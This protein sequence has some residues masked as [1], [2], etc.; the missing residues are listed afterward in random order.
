MFNEI[1]TIVFVNVPIKKFGFSDA[2]ACFSQKNPQCKPML[3]WV[4]FNFVNHMR[5]INFEIGQY[6]YIGRFLY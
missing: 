5:V 3:F 4:H 6:V 1:L 2:I